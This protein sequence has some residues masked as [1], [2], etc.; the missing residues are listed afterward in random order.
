[1]KDDLQK[2]KDRLL[3]AVANEG[4]ETFFG[5]YP[6]EGVREIRWNSELEPDP[7]KFVGLAKSVGVK[8]IYINWVVFST[9]DLEEAMID[10]EELVDQEQTV[11]ADEHNKKVSEFTQYVGRIASVRAGFFLSEVFH[12][13]EREAEWYEDFA[14]ILGEI[15][16]EEDSDDDSNDDPEQKL[17][18]EAL[19]WADKLARDPS[20]GRTK[21]WSQHKYLLGKLAGPEVSALPVDAVI[22][23]AQTIYEVDVRP[24]EEKQLAEE[25]R[26]MKE[27]GMSIV[28]IAGK[29]DLS[30]ERVQRLLAK[31]GS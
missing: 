12:L 22:L 25:I 27:G 16:N 14:D 19:A 29:L 3:S 28:A 13:Y 26:Q 23:R 21:G 30:R 7:S 11:V 2:I 31:A 10:E 18:D 5:S 17:S 1:M 15:E 8:I 9:D 20:F 6:S 4:I 24:E